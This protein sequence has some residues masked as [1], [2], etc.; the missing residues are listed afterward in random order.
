MIYVISF[1]SDTFGLKNEKVNTIN[2]I[3]GISVGEWLNPIL[4]SKGV[5]LTDIDEEDWGWYSYATLA[6]QK[7]LIGYIA[8][9]ENSKENTAEIII[10]V[11]K[12][13]TIFEKL[14]GK[15]KLTSNDPLIK[16]VS[17][18]IKNTKEFKGIE[19]KN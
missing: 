11:H 15:N 16:E 18:I 12:E 17:S 1:Y 10:Q 9:P 13:R 14:F 5:S 4:A 8:I 19:E 7:Y 2:P 6:N 3:K